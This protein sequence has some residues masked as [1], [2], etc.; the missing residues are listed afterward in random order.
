MILL[1]SFTGCSDDLVNEAIDKYNTDGEPTTST[2]ATI[3]YS[4]GTT[5]GVTREEA[6]VNGGYQIYHIGTGE[7]MGFIQADGSVNNMG[8]E[9]LGVC[10]GSTV[11]DNGVLG[12]CTVPTANPYQVAVQ[13]QPVS[14]PK[15]TCAFSTVRTNTSG[16]CPDTRNGDFNPSYSPSVCNSNG[17]FWCSLSGECLNKPINVPECGEMSTR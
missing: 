2:S 17:Y 10:A 15:T 12:D 9:E 14:A 13:P 16:T 11:S 7:V 1:L 6:A 3:K 8:G 4:D 5:M